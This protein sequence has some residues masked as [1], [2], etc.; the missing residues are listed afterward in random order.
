[1]DFETPGLLPPLG[2]VT[3]HFRPLA[4][5]FLLFPGRVRLR[6]AYAGEEHGPAH[7][8]DVRGGGFPSLLL[9]LRDRRKPSHRPYLGSVNWRGWGLRTPRTCSAGVLGRAGSQ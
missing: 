5:P 2:R 9:P 4:G 6:M 8:L 3:H 1:M 7:G